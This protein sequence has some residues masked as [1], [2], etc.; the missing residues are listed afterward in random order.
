MARATAE[1]A[2]SRRTRAHP[3]PN[4]FDVDPFQV[5]DANE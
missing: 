3:L 2:P 5:V 1:S 4:H